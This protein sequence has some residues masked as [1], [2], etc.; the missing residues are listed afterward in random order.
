MGINSKFEFLS[1]WK[2]ELISSAVVLLCLFLAVSFPAQGFSQDLSRA[3]FILFL[4]P[5]LYIKFILKQ[6]LRDFGL[7][8]QNP[9]VG[10]FWAIGMLSVSFLAII[11]LIRF[12][13]FEN[14]YLV[15]AYLAKSFGLFLFYELIVMN[16]ILFVYDFF[17]KGFLLFLL[18]KKFGFSAVFIQALVFISFMA[19][20]GILDWKMAPFVILSLTGGIAA[21]Q[22]RSFLY[23]YLASLV[24][25]MFLDAYIIHIFK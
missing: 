25:I 8:L 13:D 10:F 11:I 1:N 19:V 12:F 5:I 7:N 16:L 22:T 20:I 18:S 6:D 21:Y 4:L 2:T 14:N 17:F 9:K 23:P 24:F 15:P 3:F